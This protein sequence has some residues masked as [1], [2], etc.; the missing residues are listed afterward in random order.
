MRASSH[1]AVPDVA[2]VRGELN[3]F[4]AGQ[5]LVRGW[6]FGDEADFSADL[7]VRWR[8]PEH[9]RGPGGCLH[10]IH[11][12]LD[13]GGL[14]GSVR[15]EQPVDLAGLNRHVQTVQRSDFRFMKKPSRY[16]FERPCSSRGVAVIF[17]LILE[18]S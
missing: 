3:E 2:E 7:G 5:V 14:P 10:Q 4:A 12:N 16:V 1:I 8:A 6:V 11:D 15:P 18:G 9:V 17:Y 13:G